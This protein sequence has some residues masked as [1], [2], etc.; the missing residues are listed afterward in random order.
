MMPNRVIRCF[1][2]PRG[3]C[4]VTSLWETDELTSFHDAELADA[5][6]E[7]NNILK[8][9]NESCKGQ[10]KELSFIEVENRL[11]LVWTEN[12]TIGPHDDPDTIRKALS[13]K[14]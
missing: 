7:I 14:K 3:D 6:K 10:D 13:L 4:K 9:L 1:K 12:E 5:T 8:R 11:F 2:S